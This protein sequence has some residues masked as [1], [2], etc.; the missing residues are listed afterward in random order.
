MVEVYDLVPEYRGRG[1]R[2]ARKQPQAGWQYLQMV[3]QRDE[4]GHFHGARLRVIFGKKFE[5]VVLLGEV[6][7]T[8][9]AA[10]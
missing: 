5:V 2:P 9:S 10:S 1:R 6:R 7:P 8:L 4:H 3:K